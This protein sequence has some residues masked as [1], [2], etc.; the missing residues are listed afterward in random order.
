[1][2]VVMRTNNNTHANGVVIMTK[3]IARVHPVHLINADCERRGG[4]T[5][6]RPSQPTWAESA[7]ING[8]TIHI[9]QRH[10]LLLLSPKAYTHFTVPQRAEGWV[11]I[12]TAGRVRCPRMYIAVAVVINT[13][14]RDLSH[15]M[16]PLNHCDLQRHRV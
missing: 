7:D 13:T 9:H 8:A 2:Y 16:P 1:M 10:L 11:N 14:A 6:P 4:G 15:R 12:G 5:N 3:A